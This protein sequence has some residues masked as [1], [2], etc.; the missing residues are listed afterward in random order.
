MKHQNETTKMCTIFLELPER[1]RIQCVALISA[2][3]FRQANKS[4][5]EWNGPEGTRFLWKLRE[6]HEE[7]G[8][9]CQ[10]IRN[11]SESR[12]AT[13]ESMSY[14]EIELLYISA[15]QKQGEHDVVTGKQPWIEI[16]NRR[17]VTRVFLA[18]AI[19]SKYISGTV[20]KSLEKLE[21]LRKGCRV[22]KTIDTLHTLQPRV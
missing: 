9:N 13:Y 17:I 8:E 19:S 10:T 11:G 12:A 14:G 2:K 6:R 3:V 20:Y 5:S 4:V 21:D 22:D 15:R 1:K 16:P 7:G 18:I